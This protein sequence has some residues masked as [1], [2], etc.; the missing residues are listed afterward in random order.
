MRVAL[1]LFFLSV[2]MS[3]QAA[4]SW[5]LQLDRWGNPSFMT[6]H[7]QDEGGKLSGTLDGDSLTGMRKDGKLRL[8]VI[9]KD[10]KH[11]LYKSSASATRLQGSAD[12]PDTNDAT[13]RA[14]HTFSARRLPERSPTAPQRHEYI[15]KDYSN[16]FSATRPP[17][18]TVWP[19]DTVH[20]TTID[21]GGVDERGVTRALYGNP[22][23]GPFF[24]MD[25][26]AGDTLVIHL[27][28]LKLNRDYADS[29]DAI[30][31]RAQSTSL[32]ARASTLGKPVRWKLDHARGLASPEQAGAA[33]RGFAVPLRPMLG[34]LAVAPPDGPAVSTGD[35][36]RFGGNMDFNE[37]VEGNKVYLPVQQP[38]ALL[39][40][41]DAHALQGDGE[42]SQYA[43]ET[44]ME[45]AFRVELIKGK[46]IG[47]PRV[48]S[49]THIMTLGQAGSLD[50]ALRQATAGMTQWLQQDYGLSLSDSA[51]VLG[52][53]VEYT[54][55][56]LAGRSVGV[57]AKIKKALLHE[58]NTHGDAAAATTGQRQ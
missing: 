49:P 36:G 56:N 22:Q 24:V 37:V 57:A 28:K 34:G 54:V 12:F 21:S 41:G 3:A 4:E 31:G 48:E 23:T 1:F 47:M 43:L 32:A 18:L 5:L 55:A 40:L 42:T 50:D 33:L 14:S 13:A 15:P 7:L 52:G 58:N 6:L 25:A 45:V 26:E 53:A 9:D 2:A 16:E 51:V 29:L 30:V 19:G 27:L 46:A 44:S 8:D 39:Y 38:G 10:G 11:Y 35:T 20:T 17:V